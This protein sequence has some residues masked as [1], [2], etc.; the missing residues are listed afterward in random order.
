MN[1]ACAVLTYWKVT[2]SKI[3]EDQFAISELSSVLSPGLWQHSQEWLCHKN[4]NCKAS[5]TGNLACALF[6]SGAFLPVFFFRVAQ[7]FLP[8]RV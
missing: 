6:P 5:G 2:S 3:L 1:P 8:V 7:A 4:Q